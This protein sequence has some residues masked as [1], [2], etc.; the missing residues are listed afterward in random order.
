MTIYHR[1]LEED[2][3]KLTKNDGNE[4]SQAVVAESVDQGKTTLVIDGDQ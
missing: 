4:E 1:V 3:A 2:E